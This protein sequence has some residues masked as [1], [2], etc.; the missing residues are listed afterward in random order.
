MGVTLPSM[1]HKQHCSLIPHTQLYRVPKPQPP[2]PTGGVEHDYSMLP[3]TQTHCWGMK[4]KGESPTKDEN[5]K[6][7]SSEHSKEEPTLLSQGWSFLS[8]PF[9]PGLQLPASPFA[10]CLAQPAFMASWGTPWIAG[11]YFLPRCPL[12]RSVSLLEERQ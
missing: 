3:C 7:S 1:G 9:W 6:T 4:R 10:G 5:K 2:Q 8:L 12:F 11:G